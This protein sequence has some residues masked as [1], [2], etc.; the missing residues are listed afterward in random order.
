MTASRLRALVLVLCACGIAGMIVSSVRGNNNGW[1]I[2][3]GFLTL[4]PALVLLAVNAVLNAERGLTVDESLAER[5]EQQVDRLRDVG[6]DEESLRRLVR[7]AVRL[8]RRA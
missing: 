3:F 5:V 7:D 4:V 6:A 2:S 1:V 8:G